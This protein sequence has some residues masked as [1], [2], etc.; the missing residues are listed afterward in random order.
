MFLTESGTVSTGSA[1]RAFASR[2][3]SRAFHA[4]PRGVWLTG[5]SLIVAMLWFALVLLVHRP[6]AALPIYPVQHFSAKAG[7][8]GAVVRGIERGPDGVMWFACWGR[9]VSSYDGFQWRSYDLEDGL[10]SYDIRCVRFDGRGLLWTGGVGGIAVSIGDRWV[11]VPT[12]LPEFEAPSVYTIC[13]LRD[14]RIWFGLEAGQVIQFTPEG[15]GRSV[16]GPKGTWSLVADRDRT[17]MGTGIA[18]VHELAD[19][20]MIIGTDDV[21]ILRYRNGAWFQGPG[22]PEVTGISSICEGSD[23]RV[24]AAGRS[25]L[26]SQA[27][28]QEGWTRE[29]TE[30]ARSV[31][32]RAGGDIAVAFLTRVEFWDGPNRNEVRLLRDTDGFLMQEI[33]HFPEVDETWVGTKLGV[34][35][36][37]RQGWTFYPHS[38]EGFWPTGNALYADSETPAIMADGNGELHQFVDGG[39]RVTGQIE[40]GNYLS[41]NRGRG[42]TL[43]FARAGRA[44]QWD[45]ETRRVLN[46]LDLPPDAR[47]VQESSSG[48][49]IAWN[50]EA[51]YQQVSGNWTK[52]PASPDAPQ[53]GVNS[54]LVIDDDELLVSTL[55]ALE[56][57]KLAADGEATS[58][59]EIHDGKNFRG[60]VREPDET[61]LVGVNEDGIYRYKDGALDSVIAFEKDPSAR[62]SCLLRSKTGRIW[63]GSLDL[64]VASYDHGRWIWY[65]EQSGFPSGGISAIS[66][67]PWGNIW[68]ELSD[69]GIL[70]YVPDPTPPETI[71]EQMPAQIPYNDRSVFQFEGRDQW[72]ITG[73]E[74]LVYASRIRPAN[75]DADSVPW[76]LFSKERSVITPQLAYG[77]YLF[78][79]R[80]ADTNFNEDPTPA[81]R[82]FTVLPPLWATPAFLVPISILALAI[83]IAAWLLFTNYR[84]LSVSE[85]RLREAKEQAE[86]ANR[87]KSQFLAHVSHEIRTPMNA[88]LGHVQVLQKSGSRS[89]EDGESLNTIIRSGDHLLELINNVLEMARIEA[90]TLNI[91]L[92]TFK[93]RECVDLILQM[94]GVQCDPNKV[95]LRAQ[96]DSSVPQYIIADHGKIRQILINLIGN[97]IKFTPTGTITLICKAEALPEHPDAFLLRLELRDTGQ[98]IEPEALNRVLEPFEQASA[99][100][101]AGGA[102]LGLPISRRQ[103]EAMDGE[104]RIESQPGA[105][106]SIYAS[107]AIR[108][109][110]PEELPGMTNAGQQPTPAAMGDIRIL[111]VDDIETNLSVMD[112][113]LK[114]FGFDV[115]GVSSGAEAIET[116]QRWKPN[117]ILMDQAMPDMNGLETTRRIRALE[118]GEKIPVIFVTGGVLD[119]DFREIMASDATDIIRKPF[120]QAELLEKIR[121]HLGIRD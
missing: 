4:D 10:P 22:D 38:E 82:A 99:G 58:L 100:R 65:G 19:G 41:I 31:S 116:F 91:N 9:G 56:H 83:L 67:D 29:A 45:L 90:G 85:Y 119:E 64:G 80:A 14:G 102:G 96:I 15:E 111:V 20:T 121:A 69:T 62:V 43:W 17:K 55:V 57:W 11:S 75:A 87:A 21:G 6:C 78:E 34:F 32:P 54:L 76:S 74:E 30:R 26:W 3:S 44:V 36:I 48:H 81:Q 37:G 113:L 93:F 110:H 40:P 106:T 95:A 49:R 105:G 27:P 33:Q 7:L 61:V 103:I 23:G 46:N 117:L 104:M 68:A 28:G 13:P 92:E 51:V 77:D 24:Y 1:R 35:R 52:S 59:H 86:A 50:V 60:L 71:I 25:G 12:G 109:G 73:R 120:R 39:W 70:R 18:G 47:N 89:E 2:R 101:R 114:L 63:S 8:A 115:V 79:V 118:G 5:R 94:L 108:A 112:K 72:D 98:G 88:I 84:V 53:E 66:E 16:D 97:A 42:N 107:F